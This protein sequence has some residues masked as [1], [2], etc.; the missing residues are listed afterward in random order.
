MIESEAARGFVIR[1]MRMCQKLKVDLSKLV[2]LLF[3][4]GSAEYVFVR[5]SD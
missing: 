4:N 1:R 5:R 3:R 2:I